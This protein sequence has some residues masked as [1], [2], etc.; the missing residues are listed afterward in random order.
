[1]ALVDPEAQGT[2]GGG[3]GYALLVLDSVART[4]TVSVEFGV[5]TALDVISA[6][7]GE[8]TDLARAMIMADHVERA[9][10]Q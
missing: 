4:A 2:T 7:D 9:F 8:G 5:T 3:E 10:V 6:I 1:M